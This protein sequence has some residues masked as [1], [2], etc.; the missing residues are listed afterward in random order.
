MAI[1]ITLKLVG[2]FFERTVTITDTT[3]TV[4]DAL[5]AAK[6]AG[7]MNF[8]LR[9]LPGVP[10]VDQ[11]VQFIEHRLALDV[12]SKG[13]KIRTKGLYR[14]QEERTPAGLPGNFR[15]EAWQYYIERPLEIFDATTNAR[16]LVSKTLPGD[17]FKVPG[18]SELL[19][20]GDI[21]I[22]RN[23]TILTGPTAA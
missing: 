13:N 12:L 11:S 10:V 9:A 5:N 4:L 21:V 7:L 15:V 19:K 6:N 14:I 2:L 23:V 20:D 3:P 17:G 16:I 18:R 1:K 8:G 22:W